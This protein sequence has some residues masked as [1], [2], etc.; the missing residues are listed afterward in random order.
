M[1]HRLDLGVLL[2]VVHDL[3]RVVDLLVD[4]QGEGLEGNQQCECV[5]RGDAGSDVA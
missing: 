4:T 1:A 5:D 3:E 2:Q